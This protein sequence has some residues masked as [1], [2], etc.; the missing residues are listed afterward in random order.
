MF[1][2]LKKL[3]FSKLAIACY[4][5]LYQDGMASASELHNRLNRS[6]SSIYLCLK[7]LEAKGFVSRTKAAQQGPTY[8][9]AVPVNQALEK[10]MSYYFYEFRAL[11]DYQRAKRLRRKY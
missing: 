7:Q 10:L 2:D 6:F 5:S 9:M 3:G 11:I 1:Q 8:F 4:Q